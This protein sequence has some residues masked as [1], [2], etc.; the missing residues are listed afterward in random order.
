VE[1]SVAVLL[2]LGDI[3]IVLTVLGSAA[4]RF[5]LSPFRCIC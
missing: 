3:L 5:G 2:V 1:V 4:R